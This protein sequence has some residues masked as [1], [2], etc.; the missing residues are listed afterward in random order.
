MIAPR[1]AKYVLNPNFIGARSLSPR[2]RS[3]QL[4]I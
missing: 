3:S 4:L 2:L 1:F